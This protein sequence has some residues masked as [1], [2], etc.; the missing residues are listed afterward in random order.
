MCVRKLP[1]K[2]RRTL[3][4]KK[5]WRTR[6]QSTFAALQQGDKHVDDR[7]GPVD[8]GTDG[9]RGMHDGQGRAGV[10]SSSR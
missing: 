10:P 8:D 3:A 4:A 2:V 6:K 7:M 5:A 1:A 9:A